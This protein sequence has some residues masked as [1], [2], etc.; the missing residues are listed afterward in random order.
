MRTKLAGLSVERLGSG[1]GPCVILLHGFGA[2]GD[3]LVPLAEVLDSPGTTWVFPAAPLQPPQLAGGRAWWMLDLERLER[4][5][6]SGQPRDLSDETPVGMSEAR[7]QV[8]A[9][10]QSLIDEGIAPERVVLG[11]FSQGAMLACDVALHLPRPP[12]AL[13]LLSGAPIA[14]DSWTPRLSQLDGVPVFQ[15]HGRADALLSFSAAETL[16]DRLRGA[17]ADLQWLAFAGGHEIPPPVMTGLAA[18]LQRLTLRR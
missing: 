15:S 11:G 14:L 1:D 10:V 8:S 18:F 16:A 12:A 7:A 5:I 17:G 2:P 4:S 6:A 13:V 9:L 3:D